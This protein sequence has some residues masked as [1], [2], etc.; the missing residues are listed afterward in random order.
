MKLR[1]N[2][3]GINDCTP[4]WKWLSPKNGFLDYDIWAVFRGNGIIYDANND[5]TVYY[6]D[7]GSALLLSPNIQYFA[8]HNPK[9]PLLVI[10][11]HFNFLDDV[12]NIVYPCGILA[13]YAA[14]PPFLKK[15]LIRV[16]TLFNNNQYDLAAAFLA[17]VLV[18][19]GISDDLNNTTPHNPW[20]NI[21][22]EITSTIDTVKNAPSLAQFALR[23]GYSER[24]VGKMFAKINNISFSQYVQNARINKSKVLLCSTSMTI[25]E[26]AE[27]T[28]FYDACYFSKTFKKIVGFSPLTFRNNHQSNT[29]DDSVC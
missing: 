20:R 24:Y 28:G 5:N 9:N 21:I 15:L 4:D 11:V 8:E 26:I 19:Y 1:I 3:C 6:V 23:Y 17:S 22:G 14:D 29:K 18:E 13:K 27:E 16:V 7:E 10:N 12:G 2:S 25:A